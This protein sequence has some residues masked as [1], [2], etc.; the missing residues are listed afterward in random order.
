MYD[1]WGSDV[2]W[3]ETLLDSLIGD[4][5]ALFPNDAVIKCPR[6]G[7]SHDRDGVQEFFRRNA[8]FF[9]DGAHDIRE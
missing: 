8:E 7:I 5:I 4:I 2:E 1:S 3:W 9:A 6:E